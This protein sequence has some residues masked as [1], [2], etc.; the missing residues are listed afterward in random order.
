M[1]SS[2]P[3]DCHGS[4]FRTLKGFHTPTINRLQLCG[5]PLGN[6]VTHFLTTETA[7]THPSSGLSATFSPYQGRRDIE[8]PCENTAMNA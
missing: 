1:G 8:E 4:E 7:N 5:T 3:Q 2:A 6:A